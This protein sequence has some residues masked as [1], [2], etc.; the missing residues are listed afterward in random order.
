MEVRRFQMVI[1]HNLLAMNASRQTGLVNR[2]QSKNIERLS[3]GYKINRAADDA[4]G[5][6]ISEKMRKQIRGLEQG[7]ANAEDGIS[8]CQVADGALSEVTDMIQRT[9][10]LAVQ[11]ANGTN[12]ES[13]RE[14]IQMEV[15]QIVQE[16][17]R[18]CET[19][20][21]NEIYLFKGK[22]NQAPQITDGTPTTKGRFFEVLGSNVST[23]GYMDEP[24][25]DTMVTDSSSYMEDSV[26]NPTEPPYVSVHINLGAIENK[27]DELVGTSFY[28]N[29]CT[30]DCPTTVTFTDGTDV[31]VDLTAEN[32]EIGLKKTDGTYYQNAEELNQ[33]I[34][35]SIKA[36]NLA[37]HVMFAYKGDMLY[38]YDVDNRNWSDT[39]KELAYF[40]DEKPTVQTQMSKEIKQVYIQSGA[41]AGD[42]IYLNITAMSSKSLGL[43]GLSVTKEETALEAIDLTSD[44]LRYVME[45]RSGIGA[46]QNRLEHTINNE[47]SIVENTTAAESQIRDA[48]MAEIMVSNT[49]SKVLLQAGQFML[50]QANQSTQGV[51]SILG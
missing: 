19:T 18:V 7:I 10:Q 40:C 49:L 50:A 34:V 27:L 22:K 4:A 44:A 25:K 17:D 41:E 47:A 51:V 48:D 13:D 38:L 12:S 2:K 20:K 29:C 11:A 16:I 36:E 39:D 46:E 21:F 14:A 23:N 24:L 28:V 15:S 26:A 32:I 45:S 35:A 31:T 43:C 30:D 3:S 9:S 42:G 5:L 1:R 33:K 8:L 6:S 37:T